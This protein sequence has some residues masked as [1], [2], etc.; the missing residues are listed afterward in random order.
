MELHEWRLVAAS[1]VGTSH[2]KTGS[3]CQDSFQWRLF[4]EEGCEEV[5]LLAASDGAGSAAHSDVGS[6]LACEELANKVQEFLAD[7]GGLSFL[8]REI[9]RGWLLDINA[10]INQRAAAE[11]GVARDYACTLL[12]TLISPTHAA[13]LQI[14]DGAMVVRTTEDEWCYI[15]WP[16]HGEY[17]NSTLFLTDRASLE[18]FEFDMREDKVH[19]IAAFTDGIEALVLHYAT[20]SVHAPFFNRMFPAVRSLP[21][22]GFSAETSEKLADY[23]NSAPVCARTDDDKTLLLASR[24]KVL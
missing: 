2:S 4:N 3:P 16:Q 1:A 11:G 8:T 7:H 13:Y 17:I 5:I 14:G 19:E 6:Q 24:I 20:N 15:F 18:K 21:Q 22:P 12:A 10:A 9:V 23:L